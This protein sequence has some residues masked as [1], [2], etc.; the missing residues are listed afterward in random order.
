MTLP[1]ASAGLSEL[2]RRA[3]GEDLGC[4]AR[5]DHRW[6]RSDSHHGVRSQ[7]FRL[8]D[9]SAGRLFARLRQKLGV[10][11][12]P[13][14]DDVPA[15]VAGLDGIRARSRSR[16]G[17]YRYVTNPRLAARCVA[18]ICE[19]NG[20]VRQLR[21]MRSLDRLLLGRDDSGCGRERRDPRTWTQWSERRLRPQMPW[22]RT[23][24]T[25]CSTSSR[26]QDDIS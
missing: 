19:H 14:A 5:G 26:S 3:A 9:H 16:Y 6:R 8:F 21:R 22:D 7:D 12:T 25:T 2:H 20:A 4:A 17:S 23:T 11:R 18:V 10:A 24:F 13:S 15:D 1:N